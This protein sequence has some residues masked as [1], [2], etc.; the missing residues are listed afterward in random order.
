MH[1]TTKESQKASTELIEVIAAVSLLFLTF[2]NLY[3]HLQEAPNGREEQKRLE[4]KQD[5]CEQI[6]PAGQNP[7]SPYKKSR[8]GS[9]EIR[10]L[11]QIGPLWAA[12][13]GGSWQG[14][15]DRQG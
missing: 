8:R 11:D 4:I 14:S 7:L 6:Q 13:S 5:R 3:D 2:I 9:Q 1:P 12:G 10:W 15:E